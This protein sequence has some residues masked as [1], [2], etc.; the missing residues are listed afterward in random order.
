MSACADYS[1][2]LGLL[3]WPCLEC[4]A[5]TL[6]RSTAGDCVTDCCRACGA[7]WIDGELSLP[8]WLP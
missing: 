8:R 4:G 5:K 1:Q 2:N 6:H 3:P 7:Q